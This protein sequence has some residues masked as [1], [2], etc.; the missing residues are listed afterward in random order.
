MPSLVLNDAGRLHDGIVPVSSWL[1]SVF[2]GAF[3]GIDGACVCNATLGILF[4][5]FGVVVV[6]DG[7][8]TGDGVNILFV[9]VGDVAVTAA[10]TRF[11]FS[12]KLFMD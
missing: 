6:G 10:L 4:W 8:D 11:F 7:V 2:G 3:G 9:S 12:A 5:S 1:L